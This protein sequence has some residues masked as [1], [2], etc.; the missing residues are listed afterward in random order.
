MMQ[1][2]RDTG[3]PSAVGPG[4]DT[5]SD[6][7]VEEQTETDERRD[8]PWNVVVMNDPVNLMSYVTLVLRKLFGYSE[9]KAAQ[10][11]MEVHHKGRSIVWTGPREKAEFYVQQLQGR[12]LLARMEQ[13]EG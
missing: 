4:T 8:L 3:R 9:E 12:Q 6:V 11:M 1:A 10:L 7:L 2:P 13:V 5:D